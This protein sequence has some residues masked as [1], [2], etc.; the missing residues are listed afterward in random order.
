MATSPDVFWGELRPSQHLVQFYEEDSAFL[1]VLEGFVVGGI[2]RGE[3]V[4]LIATPAHRESLDQR[5]AQQ[6]IVPG[7]LGDQY[8]VLDAEETLS[9]FMRD[10]WPDDAQFRAC[11]DAIIARA[12]AYGRPVRAF[13]E[14]VAVLWAR[15]DCGATVRLEHLW[16]QLCQE[17]TFSLLCAYPKAG[18]TANFEQSMHEI[19]A[20]HSSVIPVR[21]H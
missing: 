1:D 5:L 14:M 3:A 18:F 2:R 11:I 7:T 21:P 10:G 19:C 6:G 20:A 9:H 8:I 4:I 16:H 13:G 15:G 17:Q 12:R